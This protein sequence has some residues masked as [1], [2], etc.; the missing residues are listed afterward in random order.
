MTLNKPAMNTF[1]KPCWKIWVISSW[2]SLTW[3][4]GTWVSL[5]KRRF[6]LFCFFKP[7]THN[8]FLAQRPNKSPLGRLGWFGSQVTVKL[9]WCQTWKEERSVLAHSH[10]GFR[11]RPAVY[12]LRQVVRQHFTAGSLELETLMFTSWSWEPRD[13]GSSSPSE[14][15]SP[16]WPETSH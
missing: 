15:I 16:Q 6:C 5:N 14:S 1:L 8:W 9:R 7:L 13:Q 3:W 11:P 10:G 2:R 4:H 12:A